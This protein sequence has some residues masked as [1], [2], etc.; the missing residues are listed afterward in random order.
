MH[1]R[2]FVATTFTPDSDF[3]PAAA[4]SEAVDLSRIMLCLNEA[5]RLETC[6][7]EAQQ[8]LRDTQ[9]SGE[10]II[11]DNGSTHSSLEIAERLGARVVNVKARDTATRSWEASRRRPASTW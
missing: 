9:V 3:Q 2:I 4:V 10:I 1:T 11:A 6:I 5:E 8:G 7:R